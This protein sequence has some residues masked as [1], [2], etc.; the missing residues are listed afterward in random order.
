VFN[1]FRTDGEQSGHENT[2]RA[3]FAVVR[4]T[5]AWAGDGALAGGRLGE[6]Q[7]LTEG[8][9]AGLMQGGTEGHLHRLQIQIA[10]L[11]ALGEDTAQQLGYFVRDLGMDRRGLF[12]PLASRSPRPGATRRSFR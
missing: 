8:R 7:Q 4:L 10:G 9:C 3:Q 6:P 2:P 5:A 11:L 1:R 12:F